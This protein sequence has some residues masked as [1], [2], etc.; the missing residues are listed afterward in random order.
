M[1]TYNQRKRIANNFYWWCNEHNAVN[2]VENVV[3]Y[4]YLLGFLNEEKI[5]DVYKVKNNKEDKKDD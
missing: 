3:H 5:L 1:I 4:L 2:S